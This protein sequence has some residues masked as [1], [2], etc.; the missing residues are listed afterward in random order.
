MANEKLEEF[1]E[2]L[3]ELERRA[4]KRDLWYLVSVINAGQ[5]FNEG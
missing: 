5:W 2:L 4:A 3:K 1:Y